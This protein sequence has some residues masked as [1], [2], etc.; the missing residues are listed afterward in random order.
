M[1]IFLFRLMCWIEQLTGFHRFDCS[2]ALFEKNA[3][4]AIGATDVHVNLN[5]LLASCTFVRTCHTKNPVLSFVLF[6][7]PVVRALGNLH[8]RCLWLVCPS[9]KLKPAFATF[10]DAGA[11]AMN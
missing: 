8:G 5:F 10:P 9:R 7:S 3:V 4:S 2:A 1:K 6:E 11:P